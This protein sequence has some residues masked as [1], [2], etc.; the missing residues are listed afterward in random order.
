VIYVYIYNTKKKKFIYNSL[1]QRTK[2]FRGFHGSIDS[3][4]AILKGFEVYYNFIRVHQAI[5]KC[6]YELATD[7]KLED[8][9]KWLELIKL[10]KAS[11]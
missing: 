1:R 2:T 4:N 9:N 7:L 6:P 8:N 11:I 5:K 3:A 10:S